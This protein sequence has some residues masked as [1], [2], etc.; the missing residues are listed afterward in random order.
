MDKDLAI[1][2]AEPGG[3]NKP[4]SLEHLGKNLPTDDSTNTLNSGVSYSGLSYCSQ[5]IPL[6]VVSYIQN[7]FSN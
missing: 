4:C 5:K 2:Q 7:M 1:F 6:A 3:G